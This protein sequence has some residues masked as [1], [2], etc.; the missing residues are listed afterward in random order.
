MHVGESVVAKSI[1][2]LLAKVLETEKV[3]YHAIL[4]AVDRKFIYILLKQRALQVQDK[5]TRNKTAVGEKPKLAEYL[6][7]VQILVFPTTMGLHGHTL[8]ITGHVMRS[9]C[10]ACNAGLGMCY[11]CGALLWMQDLH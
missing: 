9:Y 7:M 8:G 2:L 11:H 6:V 4:W 1:P 10:A 5:K 3:I